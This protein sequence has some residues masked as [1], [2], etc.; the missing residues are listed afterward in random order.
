MEEARIKSRDTPRHWALIGTIS[1]I[2]PLSCD[3][4][5]RKGAPP[6]LIIDPRPYMV[7]VEEVDRRCR[8]I[9]GTG[10]MSKSSGILRDVGEYF[11]NDDII[12]ILRKFREYFPGELID[13]TTN[14]IGL[15]RENV[16]QLA[17]L[18][19]IQ[20][21]VSL[22]SADPSVRAGVM[23]DPEPEIAIDGIK[24]LRKF[25]IPFSGTIVGWP[26][27]P[28]YDIKNT[29][30]YLDENEAMT[31]KINLPGYSRFFPGRVAFDT[32]EKW[33]SLVGL[34][35]DMREHIRTPLTWEPFMYRGSPTDPIVT[36]VVKNSP[37]SRAGLMANDLIRE[38]DGVKILFREQARELMIQE[39][40]EDRERELLVERNGKLI[41]VHM[42]DEDPDPED[43][44]PHK[45]PFYPR[46]GKLFGAM[47][48][49]GL[50][51]Y[52]LQS[53]RALAA[54][55]DA[56]FV[57]LIS[58][59]ILSPHVKA[60][61]DSIKNT[62]FSGIHLDVVPAENRF[63]GGN[64]MIGDLLVVPDYVE[65]IR[66]YMNREGRPDLVIIPGTAFIDGKDL[67]GQDHR[68]ISGSTGIP[69]E[70]LSTPRILA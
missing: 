66:D 64:I 56:H 31:I 39:N 14:G 55:H 27:I 24:L 6:G 45:P 2:C 17:G 40:D 51:V 57:L 12:A 5:L 43:R 52:G 23:R 60:I 69:V 4:C 54:K 68:I 70:L 58:S 47:V 10:A 1:T 21:Q 36:G 38:V 30:R 29:I 9:I 18:V 61:I 44:Y 20:L 13:F 15:T 67:M 7:S 50:D 16:S 53:I 46:E 34:V 19:P 25:R 42:R 37:A 33:S 3:F 11:F 26:T 41:R 8:E 59:V 63:F 35:N 32:Q 22:N 28:E 49:Q 62:F 48:H 65:C